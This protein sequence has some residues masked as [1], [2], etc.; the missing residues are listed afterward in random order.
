MAE[1]ETTTDILNEMIR[2]GC[3]LDRT[4]YLA[5]MYGPQEEWPKDDA[6]LPGVFKTVSED[7]RVGVVK[8]SV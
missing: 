7:D 8:G 6:A 4:A 5:F 3:P 1:E 2:E